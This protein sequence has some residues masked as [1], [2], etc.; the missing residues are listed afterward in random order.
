MRRLL[1]WTFAAVVILSAGGQQAL[2]KEGHEDPRSPTS[3]PAK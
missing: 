2:A 1:V 3:T